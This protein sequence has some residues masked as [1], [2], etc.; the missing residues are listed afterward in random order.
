MPKYEICIVSKE[1]RYVE[2]EAD[3]ENEAKDKAWDKVACGYTGDT[4]AE[5]C[6]TE[7]YIERVFSERYQVQENFEELRIS[8]IDTETGESRADYEYNDPSE[9]AQNL[10]NANEECAEL[11]ERE[12]A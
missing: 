3:N 8:I 11:N 5:D 10:R 12:T 7:L 9:R 1:Y 6:D 4:K 2:I